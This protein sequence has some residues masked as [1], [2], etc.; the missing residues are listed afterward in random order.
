MEVTGGLRNVE[1][2]HFITACGRRRGT[3]KRIDAFDYDRSGG[4]CGGEIHA[5]ALNGRRVTVAGVY[6]CGRRRLHASLRRLLDP[7]PGRTVVPVELLETERALEAGRDVKRHQRRFDC[8]RATAAHR[9][10]E[11]S[12]G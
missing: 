7:L 10:E 5:A 9:I 6:A 8:D 11:R 1:A 2:F 3:R 4:A 12:A